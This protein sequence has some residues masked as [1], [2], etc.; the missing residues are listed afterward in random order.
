MD[1]PIEIQSFLCPQESSVSE[2]PAQTFCKPKTNYKF[3]FGCAKQV[4]TWFDV[5][6]FYVRVSSD[7]L[8]DVPDSL[9]IAYPQRP[10]P[11]ELEVN[12]G[13]IS[14]SE[15]ACFSLRRDRID[16]DSGEATYVNTNNLRT[17]GDLTFEIYDKDELL[18]Y[19]SLFRSDL[20]TEDH[21]SPKKSYE[22][23]WSMECSC[24]VTSSVCRFLKRKGDFSTVNPT[25]EVY[26]AGR[27]YGFPIVLSQTVQL[28][29]RRKV[30]RCCPLDAIPEDDESQSIE[31]V[32]GQIAD[33]RAYVIM[34]NQP[35]SPSFSNSFYFPDGGGFEE[36]EE[37]ELSWFNAGVR[38][39][40]GIGLGMCLG[41]GVGVGLLMR[42]YHATTVPFRRRF[43]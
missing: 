39:G 14:P 34:S 2:Y 19:G 41:I 21:V 1:D 33:E 16:T 25:M 4:Q 24:G 12:G 11:S 32:A 35:S 37:G 22:T 3:S 30:F 31:T 17:T 36:G 13:R 29:A 6:V 23:G 27:S 42:T 18:V 40:V 8:D 20:G 7:L 10:M 9:L 15:R 38:V 26:V 43:F 28:I 5:K